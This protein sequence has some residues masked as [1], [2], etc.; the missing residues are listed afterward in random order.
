MTLILHALHE[1]NVPFINDGQPVNVVEISTG[2]SLS[3]NLGGLAVTVI[4]SLTSP[5]GRAQNAVS[6]ARRHAP[7]YLDV[8]KD[9]QWREAILA[10]LLAKEAQIRKLPDKYRARIRF[11]R[12]VLPP[13]QHGPDA[14]DIAIKQATPPVGGHALQHHGLLY[15]PNMVATLTRRSAKRSPKRRKQVS[16][17]LKPAAT[18]GDT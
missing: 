4:A 6:A 8:E 11:G 10:K 17:S 9:P 7:E 1:N 2:L 14:E 13:K 18:R 5:K 15:T 16:R 3:V 12:G